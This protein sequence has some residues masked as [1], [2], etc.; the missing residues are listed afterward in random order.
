[1]DI[2]DITEPLLLTSLLI[3][4]ISLIYFY[5]KY[6]LLAVLLFLNGIAS[7]IYHRKQGEKHWDEKSGE[8]HL[9]E[10]LDE[11]YLNDISYNNAFIFDVVSSCI[12]FI[13]SVFIA[14][15]LQTQQKYNLLILVIITFS[16]YGLNY[17][18]KKYNYH[19]AW[20]IFVLLGQLFL[21]LNI[22]SNNKRS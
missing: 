1:M 22:K 19:L 8:K 4:P 13:L 17:Y 5:K 2:K 21:A 12:S 14:K 15:N 7:Y 10:K 18:Y 3:L 6:Y 16:F 11:K 9:D 20:H